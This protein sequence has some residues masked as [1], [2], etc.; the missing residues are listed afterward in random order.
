MAR[1]LVLAV[2]S[3][4]LGALRLLTGTLSGPRSHRLAPVAVPVRRTPVP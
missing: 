2:L 4:L 3:R 1:F